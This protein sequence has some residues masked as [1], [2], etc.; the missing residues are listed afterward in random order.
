M[1]GGEGSHI[2][3]EERGEQVT[4]SPAQRPEGNAELR[5]AGRG[6][7]AQ[8]AVSAGD[9]APGVFLPGRAQWAGGSGQGSRRGPGEQ[10]GPRGVQQSRQVREPAGLSPWGHGGR[11][12]RAA[13][14]TAVC[15]PPARHLCTLHSECCTLQ[16]REPTASRQRCPHP[17]RCAQVL[18]RGCGEGPRQLG[19]PPRRVPGGGPCVLITETP[20][21]RP[22]RLSTGH[23]A[24]C[25]PDTVSGIAQDPTCLTAQGKAA[26][27]SHGAGVLGKWVPVQLASWGPLQKLLEGVARGTRGPPS[28]RPRQQPCPPAPGLHAGGSHQTRYGQNPT[29]PR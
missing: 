26:G 2:P 19:P 4:A 21:P 28:V 11:R 23:L 5:G 22:L 8:A 14:L 16:R 10:S 25:L 27:P 12:D 29:P 3:G 1:N 6:P 15:P 18:C 20:R 24:F 9:Q 17:P 13:R 7:R